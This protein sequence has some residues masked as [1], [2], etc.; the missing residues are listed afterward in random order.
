[1]EINVEEYDGRLSLPQ[2]DVTEE[3]DDPTVA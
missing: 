2:E 3:V 1:M